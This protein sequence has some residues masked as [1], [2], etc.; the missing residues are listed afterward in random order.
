M[1]LSC[2]GSHTLLAGVFFRG[3]VGF[4][5]AQTVMIL[6]NSLALEIV[7][8]RTSLLTRPLFRTPC[9]AALAPVA[10]RR[11]EGATERLGLLPCLG[12]ANSEACSTPESTTH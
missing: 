10:P 9:E 1:W 7:V 3:T 4:S 8:L 2:K 11:W 5:R 12:S 6:G